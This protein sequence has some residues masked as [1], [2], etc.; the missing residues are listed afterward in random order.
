MPVPDAAPLRTVCPGLRGARVR[1][2]G[3]TQAER[4]PPDSHVLPGN[5]SG[6]AHRVSHAGP[7]LQPVPIVRRDAVRRL[8]RCQE[9]DRSR[10]PCRRGPLPSQRE[11]AEG[12]RGPRVA[13][14][15]EGVERAL[16][17][18]LHVPEDRLPAGPP[19][20]V[21]GA[22]A[23]RAPADLAAALAL[24]VLPVHGR[25]SLPGTRE[26]SWPTARSG[27]PGALPRLAGRDRRR[28]PVLPRVGRVVPPLDRGPRPRKLRPPRG[29][30][31]SRVDGRPAAVRVPRPHDLRPR[32]PFRPA[33]L[34]PRVAKSPLG[35]DPGSLF[36]RVGRPAARPVPVGGF[37]SSVVAH[38][39]SVVRRPDR[40]DVD[41]GEAG[42]AARIAD[43]RSILHRSARPPHHQF[44]LGVP[45]LVFACLVF[46]IWRR[47]SRRRPAAAFSV[48]GGGWL[49]LGSAV[50]LYMV[51]VPGNT[52]RWIPAHDWIV[53]L[54]FAAFEILGVI[55]E[56]LL[57]YVT[58]GLR[59]WRL[60]VRAH[61]ILATL[62]LLLVLLS[63]GLAVAG[64]PRTSV[65][66]A[67]GGFGA[68][69]AMGVS[70]AV[71]TLRTVAAISRPAAPNR[72]AP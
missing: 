12:I 46:G 27:R 31:S 41:M 57:P 64:F 56:I 4:E 22:Q 67:F 3:E 52:S 43:R 16:A 37:R 23:R 13:R 40:R 65:V 19:R 2:L 26:R 14:L 66:L 47:S 9:E 32:R 55:H 1:S 39:R 7:G 21:R 69:V 10:E 68:L 11:Q 62:G 18:G 29:P 58:G 50:A 36:D 63:A 53:L 35:V 45:S 30:L 8:G 5:R 28:H 72:T 54:G 71:G 42:P 48:L 60:G 15:P 51:V 34:G 44:R 49:V 6:E 33:V 59:P 38:R 20:Q 24:R 25:V 70:V 17:D 61:E